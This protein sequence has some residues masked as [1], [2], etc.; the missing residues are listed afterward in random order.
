MGVMIDSKELS[1]S[2]AETALQRLPDFAYRLNLD[3]RN[4]ISWHAT[5]DGQDV[6]ETKEPLSSTWRRLQAWILKVAPEKQL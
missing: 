3:E 5:I 2:L 6:V 1:E 4:R